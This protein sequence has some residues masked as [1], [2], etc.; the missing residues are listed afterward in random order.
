M[1]APECNKVVTKEVE[2]LLEADFIREVF[3]PDWLVNV[4]MVK[5][6]NGK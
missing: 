5:N 4:V 3:Y 2:K 6:S 1:F